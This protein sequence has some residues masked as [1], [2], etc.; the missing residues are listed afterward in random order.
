LQAA[1]AMEAARRLP[2]LAEFL[3]EE[4]VYSFARM[5]KT[6]QKLDLKKS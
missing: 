2:C 6:R 4:L 5:A 1:A 3:N